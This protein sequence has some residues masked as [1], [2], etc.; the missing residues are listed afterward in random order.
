MSLPRI[1]ASACRKA[2]GMLD[3]PRRQKYNTENVNCQISGESL[4]ATGS[5]TFSQDGW[6]AGRA[7][8][9]ALALVVLA[10]F[11]ARLAY[12][13]SLPGPWYLPDEV[14]YLEQAHAIAS[15]GR[16]FSYGL[17]GGGQPGWP[18]VLAPVLRVLGD[19]PDL[20]YA[21]GAAL[22]SLIGTLVILPVFALARRALR[23][24]EAIAVAALAG[25]LPGSCLYGWSVLSEP[26][27]TLLVGCAAVWLVRAVETERIGD[28]AGAALV[29]GLSYWVR[30]FGMAAVLACLAGAIAWGA[31][32][33]RW[34]EPL[35]VLATSAVVI[36]AG[37]ALRMLGGS[38]AASLTHYGAASEQAAIDQVLVY[39]SEGQGWLNLAGSLGR[40]F[41]Y[42]F[43]ATFGVFFSLALAGA[44]REL[45]H[46]RRLAP[47]EKAV[48]VAG[49]AFFVLTVGLTA[50]AR[51]GTP[52]LE[53]ITQLARM[54]GRY[55]EPLLPLIVVAGIVA[56][57]RW[58]A[59]R[60]AGRSVLI[61]VLAL[62][63]VLGLTL[64]KGATS[65]TNSPGFWYWYLIYEHVPALVALAVPVA[66]WLV[67]SLLGRRLVAA[68]VLLA[69]VGAVST[70]L[71][72]YHVHRYNAQTQPE[73]DAAA[74]AVAAVRRE[75]TPD[76]RTTLWIDPT[77]SVAGSRLAPLAMQTTCWLRQGLPDVNMR[78]AR[79]EQVVAVG[80]LLL[81]AGGRAE[82][83]CLWQRH[84]IGIYRIE[85]PGSWAPPPLLR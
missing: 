49:A 20:A 32:R 9:F 51:L 12:A 64:P 74:E 3:V 22:A 83:E 39:L 33:R 47:R 28:F 30:P 10:V 85:R 59:D 80:D 45:L 53:G 15:E 70:A 21:V 4:S 24:P 29:A 2:L 17:Y 62:V 37:P 34:R 42:L 71:V 65:F 6:D 38:E 23:P 55:V 75:A 16:L 40:D 8:R 14:S 54:Y 79:Q 50:L 73:R 67:F 66:A 68:M 36:G 26:L 7:S 52:A 31:A 76:S 82:W 11:A 43:V 18:L 58:L 5:D 63:L 72:A 56:W 46:F 48:V 13:L 35:A 27:Y 57:R 41:A 81:T 25:V 44:V 19:R 60:Q 84:G 69:A 78:F 77:L 61:V 1:L